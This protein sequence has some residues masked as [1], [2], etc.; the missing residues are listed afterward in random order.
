MDGVTF[1]LGDNRFC[2]VRAD[3][4]F[5]VWLMAHS[6]GVDVTISDPRSR[7]LQI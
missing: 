1:R 7:V 5:E 2:Y 4:P 6:G 3:G